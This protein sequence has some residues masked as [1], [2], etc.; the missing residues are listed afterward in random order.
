[1]TGA[2]F[3]ERTKTVTRK[4]VSAAAALLGSKGGKAGTGEAKRRGGSEYYRKLI[5]KRWAK[6]K[7]EK[8][9]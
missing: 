7:R 4:K 3:Y 5:A 1:L 2:K 6:A 8:E 9:P